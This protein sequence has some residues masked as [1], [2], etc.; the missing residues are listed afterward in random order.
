MQ[1]KED[2]EALTVR[3]RLDSLPRHRAALLCYRLRHRRPN[4]QT[5]VVLV[6]TLAGHPVAAAGPP[7]APGPVV[8]LVAVRVLVVHHGPAPGVVAVAA[9]RGGAG[10]GGEV[11][12]GHGEFA[13]LHRRLLD[14]AH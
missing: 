14:H 2:R 13:R 10:E 5:R 8:S 7:V 6:Q 4:S 12:V 11:L 3:R 1:E 9:G